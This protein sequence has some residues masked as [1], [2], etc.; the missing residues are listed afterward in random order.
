MNRLIKTSALCVA[1]T[2]MTVICVTNVAKASFLIETDAATVGGQKPGEFGPEYEWGFGNYTFGIEFTVGDKDIVVTKLGYADLNYHDYTQSGDGLTDSHA[3]G[4]WNNNGSHLASLTVP[5]G[6]ETTLANGY[7]YASLT[8]ALTLEAGHTYTLGGNT[9]GTNDLYSF[10]RSYSA[11]TGISIIG[12]RQNAGT[13]LTYPT[14][15]IVSNEVWGSANLQYTTIPEPGT[16][17][18]LMVG[19]CGILAYAWRKQK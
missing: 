8:N 6:T 16:L 15:G 19:V 3:V 5:A 7:R 2:V 18:L 14:D 9:T 11:G 1:A 13:T 10:G 17:L 4:I 12:R